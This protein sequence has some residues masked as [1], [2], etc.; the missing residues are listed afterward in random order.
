VLDLF[1]DQHIG[2]M[3]LLLFGKILFFYFVNHGFIEVRYPTCYMYDYSTVRVICT[4][5][6]PYVFSTTF[7]YDFSVLIKK[8]S[9]VL[10]IYDYGT[11]VIQYMITYSRMLRCMA[12]TAILRV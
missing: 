2:F 11:C 9:T 1:K 8:C 3:R 7:K 4:I 6:V 5:T 10:V 12:G